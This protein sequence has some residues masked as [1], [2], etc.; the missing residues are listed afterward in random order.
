MERSI[1]FEVIQRLTEPIRYKLKFYQIAVLM[2]VEA[3]L[4]KLVLKYEQN[5][6]NPKIAKF[7]TQIKLD[8]MSNENARRTFILF[9]KLYSRFKLCLGKFIYLSLNNSQKFT[10]FVDLIQKK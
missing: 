4:S 5:K 3:V 6:C 7:H 8:L 9:N 10:F 2:F 1:L